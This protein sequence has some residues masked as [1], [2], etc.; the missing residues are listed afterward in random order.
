MHR[1]LLRP[2]WIA[3]HLVIAALVVLMV[4]LGFWQLRRLDQ[5]QER[6]AAV[7][8]RSALAEEPIGDWLNPSSTA[9]DVAAAE[10]RPLSARGSYDTAATVLIRNRSLDGVPGY[11]VVT[12]IV[13]GDGTAVLVNR[14]FI[15]RG[16]STS[17]PAPPPAPSGT[18]EVIGR[19]RPTQ[20]RGMFGL[21]DPDEGTLTEAHRI[22]VAR[23]AEQLPHPVI[24]AYLELQATTPQ[25]A[26]PQP[27]LLPLPEL[28]EGPHLSYA[29][30]WFLFSAMAIGG[31]F[32]AVRRSS[33]AAR[34]SDRRR[35]DQQEQ[36]ATEEP[37]TPRP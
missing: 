14:G 29:I 21:S 26:G 35:P 25:P 37:A 32:L 17:T 4:S 19:V 33:S 31:W 12:P 30:Q 22:D 13:T 27:A 28:D 9:D 3:F 20:A 10:W 2:K 34:A 15:P 5:R 8:E 24:P 36:P 18:V 6:N 1:S 7:R 16:S 11:H 23:L